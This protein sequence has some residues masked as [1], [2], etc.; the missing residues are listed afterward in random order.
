MEN[1][2]DLEI[3][4]YLRTLSIRMTSRNQLIFDRLVYNLIPAK[5]DCFATNKQKK[6]S[7]L[8]SNLL[9]KFKVKKI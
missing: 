4:L 2:L 1:D 3:T 6:N 8:F 9:L 5:K 7:Y